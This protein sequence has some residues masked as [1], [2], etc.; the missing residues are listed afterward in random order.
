MSQSVEN[1][2]VWTRADRVDHDAGH[3]SGYDCDGYAI[4]PPHEVCV[5]VFPAGEDRR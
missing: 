5:H 2:Y 1:D 3:P 4:M